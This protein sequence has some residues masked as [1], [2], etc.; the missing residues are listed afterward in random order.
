MKYIMAPVLIT[1]VLASGCASNPSQPSKHYPKEFS[2]PTSMHRTEVIQAVRQCISAKLKPNVEY[3]S[4][5][6]NQGVVTTPVN[7]H[8]DGTYN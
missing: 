4:V 6:T 3:L 2:E 7:V 8:C 5:K 1:T